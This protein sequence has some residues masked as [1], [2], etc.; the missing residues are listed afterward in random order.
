MPPIKRSKK[1]QL[2]S[3]EK[4]L[5]FELHENLKKLK[6]IK[7]NP[8]VKLILTVNPWACEFCKEL[9]KVIK[10]NIKINFKLAAMKKFQC[11]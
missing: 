3:P 11:A 9:K 7:E 10:I 4:S 6:V 1:P 8:L 5:K 2:T